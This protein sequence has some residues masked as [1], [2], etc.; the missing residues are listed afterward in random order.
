MSISHNVLSVRRPLLSAQPFLHFG[1]YL[2]VFFL[3]TGLFYFVVR[4][5]RLFLGLSILL[6]LSSLLVCQFRPAALPYFPIWMMMI[7]AFMP[8]SLHDRLAF[9]VPLVY[10]V[11]ILPFLFLTVSNLIRPREFRLA[12]SPEIRLAAFLLTLAVV[13]SV[14][15][16]ANHVEALLYA[17]AWGLYGYVVLR[18]MTHLSARFNLWRLAS[19]VATATMVLAGIGIVKYVLSNEGSIRYFYRSNPITSLDNNALIFLTV[20]VGILAFAL[21]L[22]RPNRRH[23]LAFVV[24]SLQIVLEQSRTGLIGLVMG[25]LMVTALVRGRRT[26]SAVA[27]WIVVAV[28]AG[29]LLLADVVGVLQ[30]GRYRYIPD[31]VGMWTGGEVSVYDLHRR[32]LVEGAKEVIRH[33]F[34]LGTGF[35]RDNYVAAFETTSVSMGGRNYLLAHNLYLTYLAQFGILGFLML[36]GFFAAIGLDLWR[37]YKRARDPALRVLLAAC[38]A[39]HAAILVMFAGNEYIIAPFPWWFWGL[40]LGI[41]YGQARRQIGYTRPQYASFR[42]STPRTLTGRGAESPGHDRP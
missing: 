22:A 11:F 32:N 26:R 8:L 23:L 6:A 14:V 2:L 27:A 30:L 17:T 7:F 20:P 35:G 37:S 18:L 28:L 21:L 41:A 3:G 5:P 34:I 36:L 1:V 15:R 31:V 39:G 40:A 42:E 10:L 33:H 12:W 19:G 29:S 4:P 16:A 24:I 25:I 9:R 38:V 13:F